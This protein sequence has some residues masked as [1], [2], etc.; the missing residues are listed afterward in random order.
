M[1]V[2]LYKIDKESLDLNST[3]EFHRQRMNALKLRACNA[4]RTSNVTLSPRTCSTIFFSSL[5]QLNHW[6]VALSL[7]L[8]SS[9]LKLSSIIA[10][11]NLSEFVH[12][13]DQS[14]N[15]TH[16]FC[17]TASCFL[18]NQPCR[19]T[20]TTLVLASSLSSTQLTGHMCKP[21]D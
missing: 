12:Q 5:K 9:F 8:T 1:L 16:Q 4:V 7:A 18:S 6:F 14:A 3:N 15:E 20:I 10:L 17:R 21:I 2:I 11:P 19:D 13:I